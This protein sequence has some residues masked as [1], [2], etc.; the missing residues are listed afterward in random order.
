[1]PSN[2]GEAVVDPPRV[3]DA[4]EDTLAA[5]V[6]TGHERS[7]GGAFTDEEPI[8]DGTA[9]G[10]YVVVG[11]IGAGGMGVVYMAFDPELGRR[12]ALKLLRR[13]ADG[14][15][16]RL[17][18]L[19]EAQALAR[20]SHP[21]VVTIYDVG[22]HAGQVFLAMEFVEG[23]TLRKWLRERSRE[24]EEV[25]RV[26]VAAGR[27]L[28]AAHDKG[29]VHRDFKPDNVMV[30]EEG[31]PRVMDFGLAQA[32]EAALSLTGASLSGSHELELVG[33]D[34]V[35]TRGKGTQGTPAYMAPEQHL[36]QPTDERTDQF[37]FCVT[38]YEA[39]Y[40]ERPFAGDSLAALSWSITEGKLVPA[41]RGRPVPSRVQ[42]AILRGLSTDAEDRWPSLRE[43]LDELEH[44]PRP[45][46]RRWIA[47]GTTLG[48]LG[49][50]VGGQQWMRARADA[51]CQAE[52]DAIAQVWSPQRQARIGE[53]LVATGVAYADDSWQRAGTQLDAYTREWAQQRA[54]ACRATT[55]E[56]ERSESALGRT[57]ACLDE[58]R[59]QLDFLLE[60]LEEPDASMVSRVASVFRQLRP[61]AE[62][63]DDAWL[64]RRPPIPDDPQRREQEDELHHRI[65][66]AD[67]MV[68]AGRYAEALELARAAVADAGPL[69]SKPLL[70]EAQLVLG[71]ALERQGAYEQALGPLQDALYIAG[72]AG[73]DTTALDAAVQLVFVAGYQLAKPEEG[74]R[75]SSIAEMFITRLGLSDDP[76]VVQWLS[77][78]GSVHQAQG[79]YDEALAVQRRALA[80]AER[81]Y[82]ADHPR[83]SGLWTNLAN[84]EHGRG[85]DEA[86]L[87]AHLRA[88]EI[89]EASMGPRHPAVADSLLNVGVAQHGQGKTY[90]AVASFERALAI[91]TEA[92]G[93]HHP[94]VAKTLNNLGAMLFSMGEAE[95]A[96][97]I[98]ERALAIQ[99]E[100]LGEEHHDMA[101]SYNNLGRVLSQLGRYDE[102]LA[103]YERALSIRV[104]TLGPEHDHVARVYAS[105]G[106]AYL[107]RGDAAAAV[108]AQRKALA[109]YEKALDDSHPS[110]GTALFNLGEAL[111]EAGE[112]AD[113]VEA[114]RRGLKV[115]EGAKLP[116]EKRGR[117]RFALARAIVAAGGDQ[118]E[119]IELAREARTELADMDELVARID[120][121]LAERGSP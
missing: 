76:D 54:E 55:L 119:A 100:A 45:A 42:R 3:G 73:H 64:A 103:A 24:H 101:G 110:V 114:L 53:A 88:L 39:I 112:A 20:L 80:M 68:S 44:D 70:A 113:A 83:V 92:L 77:N 49:A 65:L 61:L 33:D 43:L 85:D 23:Q 117:A 1:M 9:V 96:L 19:R 14:E 4:T 116:P 66:R 29:I 30:D 26:L 98:Y 86:A 94:A 58:R 75:W 46:R 12:V 7:D 97:A 10:R 62:C 111:L 109:I 91:Q 13:K 5:T 118:G 36:R 57:R 67:V 89:R 41:P 34:A 16:A 35:L 93:E 28:V 90:E 120:A 84:A 22:E 50:V 104:K 48:V 59:A 51:A 121:W 87:A 40:G 37:S 81:I 47:A 63:R 69:D 25:L 21:N 6:V 108:E 52:G 82:G 106:R 105:M 27:G 95:R 78:L 107:Q 11:R 32:G 99:R 72:G 56:Q 60:L 79:A 71:Q 31:R 102:A 15:R 2:P 18:L 74:L 115:R 8:P 17:R 38:L